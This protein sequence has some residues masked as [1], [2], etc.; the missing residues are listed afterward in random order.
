MTE[1]IRSAMP[2][3]RPLSPFLKRLE[4][5]EAQAGVLSASELTTPK[6]R[7]QQYRALESMIGNTPL[8]LIPA[9]NGSTILAKVTSQNPSESHYDYATLKILEAL[10]KSDMIAPGDTLVEATSGSLGI[11]FAYMCSRLGFKLRILVPE[12][13]PVE[14]RREMEQFGANVESI[15]ATETYKNEPDPLK[16]DPEQS[17]FGRTVKRYGEL[18]EELT[19]QTTSRDQRQK[20][21]FP[22]G[23]K[24]VRSFTI[25]GERLCFS[26]HAESMVTPVAFQRIGQ[27]ILDILPVGVNIDAFVGA[28]GNGS[29]LKGITTAINSKVRAVSP[30]MKVVGVE[31]LR[32]PTFFVK[33]YGEDHFVKIFGRKP[34]YDVQDSWGQSQPGYIPPFVNENELDEIRLVDVPTRDAVRQDYNAGKQDIETVG[35]TS[36][37]SLKV[38]RDYAREHPGSTVLILFYDKGARY[39]GGLEK[40][41]P[42][43]N[44]VDPRTHP[45]FERA[46]IQ[47]LGW[48]QDVAVSPIQL[49]RR[50]GQVYS[51]TE[52][53][54][55]VNLVVESKQAA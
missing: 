29:T 32:C 54:L 8:M 27:E 14:R 16:R 49:P 9:E 24:A 6:A 39:S 41:V 2:E 11:S 18:M 38:A 1:A 19:K 7:F 36:A 45:A 47:P 25:N 15:S 51:P 55:R 4:I 33:K 10:E 13:L 46:M 23:G 43:A 37:S 48:K 22:E 5:R 53:T 12:D 17:S 44:I 28:V 40:I 3:Q 30:K 52:E 42:G 20:I 35:N 26:N 34:S 21:V 50:L 31:N